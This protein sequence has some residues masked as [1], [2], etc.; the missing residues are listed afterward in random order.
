MERGMTFDQVL[1]ALWRRKLLVLAVA[2]SVL[3]V[4]AA[5]VAALPSVYKATAVVRMQPMQPIADMVQPTVTEAVERR[6]YTIRDEL[7][8][9]PVLQ[10]VIEE[11]NLYPKIVAKKGMDAAVAEMR[12]DLEVKVEGDSAFEVTYGADDPELAAK[13]VNRIPQ[14]FA[15]LGVKTRQEAADRAEKLFT[16]EVDDLKQSVV[17]WEK[18]ITQFKVDHMGELPE[19]LEVNM[20]GLERVSA[21]IAR[22]YDELRAAEIRRADMLRATYG[23]DSEAGQLQAQELETQRALVSARAQY[24]PDHP[25]V[26]R[27]TKELAVIRGKLRDADARRVE[28]R[29]ERARMSRVISDLQA[30]IDDLHQQAD[31]YQKRLDHTPRW[32]E[33]LAM[34]Q[35]DYDIARAKYDSVISRKVEATLAKELEARSA[36]DIF[37]VISP[38]TVPVRPA[39][40]DRMGG[41]LIVALIALG[42]GLL[43]AI[44]VEARDDSIRDV[45]EVKQQLP[46]LPVLA[47][48]PEL[49]GKTE[50]RVLLPNTVQVSNAPETLN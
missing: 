18:K 32:A 10:K 31:A 14:V 5:I 46:V 40:P 45:A 36:K 9:R 42:L 16:D 8:A 29:N 24:T 6:I 3:A 7:L 12:K 47:V 20:R 35:K 19:Q 1:K 39:S 41:I 30:S 33:E 22:R 50:K 4:G 48:V 26:Q 34:M 27:L 25:E 23:G 2:G 17:A 21:D 37:R 38:G 43:T 28:E 15:E 44:L 11:N 49:A 13:V